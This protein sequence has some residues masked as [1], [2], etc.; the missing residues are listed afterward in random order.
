VRKRASRAD[1]GD[2]QS[3]PW[4]V[5]IVCALLGILGA[6]AI[7]NSTAIASFVSGLFDPEPSREEQLANDYFRET[8]TAQIWVREPFT[9]KESNDYLR[10]HLEEFDPWHRRR[11][12]GTAAKAYISELARDPHRFAGRSVI[13][14]GR[15]QTWNIGSYVTVDPNGR[16]LPPGRVAAEWILQ[17]APL[18][19]DNPI[20]YCR[21]PDDPDRTFRDG[22]TLFVRGLI[23]AHGV[24]A[25][26]GGGTQQ[27]AY[28]AC[29]AVRRPA[30]RDPR[31]GL[32]LLPGDPRLKSQAE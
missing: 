24:V 12:R 4:A 9:F 30:G 25:L 21:L 1:G 7:Q 19:T 6:L 27:A 29:S 13:T 18:S 17:L 31:T 22:E 16:K 20:I 10:T 8:K 5:G 2:R 3:N 26:Q 15:L 23:V 32:P 11:L 14:V 28:L